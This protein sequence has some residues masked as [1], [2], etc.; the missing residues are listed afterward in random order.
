MHQV[1]R[2]VNPCL[3]ILLLAV[4]CLNRANQVYPW[5]TTSFLNSSL[6]LSRE[7]IIPPFSVL[8]VHCSFLWCQCQW[9]TISKW[10]T[11]VEYTIQR[12]LSSCLM[13]SSIWS[14]YKGLS[15]VCCWTSQGCASCHLC[16]DWYE[17]C[18]QVKVAKLPPVLTSSLFSM[19]KELCV[20]IFS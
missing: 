13:Q 12:Q 7:C 11:V 20:T 5:P 2:W 4:S 15:C 6:I 16:W 17:M 10:W 3:S 8:S 1:S 19:K 18:W 14:V 9:V